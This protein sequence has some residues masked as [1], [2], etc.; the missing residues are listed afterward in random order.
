V[1]SDSSAQLKAAEVAHEQAQARCAQLE[2]ELAGLGQAREELTGK[3]AKEQ[4]VTAESG[5][6]LK[7]LEQHLGESAKEL[8]RAKAE[9][10]KQANERGRVEPELRRQLEAAGATIKQSEAAQKQAQARCAQL[11]Q[12]LAGLRQA[13]EELAGK[14]AKE[15]QSAAA[16]RARI[17][18]LK[19][20]LQSGDVERGAQITE[21]EQRVRQ[22][23]AALTRATADLAKE[24]GERQR[25]E[26]CAAAL[27]ARLQALHEE[28]SRTLQS[29][30][31]NLERISTLEEQLRQR[32]QAVAGWTAAIE[33]QQAESRV[34]EEQLRQAKDLNAQF[35]KN[36]SFF[37][38]ASKTFDRTRQDLQARLEASLSAVQESESKL[39]REGA[40]R[41]RLADALE[42]VQREL[43]SQSQ[44]RETLETQLQ[45]TLKALKE[46]EARLQKQAAERQ[47]LNDA[48][49]TAQFS[50]RDRSQR[51]ELEFSKLQSDLQLEQVERKRLETQIARIRHTSL[52]AVRAAR[53]LRNSLRRQIH[54]PVDNLYHSARSLLE[55]QMGD[56]QKKLVEAVL[57]DVLLVQARLQ[58]PEMAQSDSSDRAPEV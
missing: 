57:Q 52:N 58:H 46:S 34:A 4:Q 10:E 48:L 26:Q 47:R 29:Q 19:R 50:L 45:T 5:K 51:G 23:V 36:L 1:K 49:E 3:F 27:N 8:E 55:L 30:R 2:Q 43:Q 6:R 31:V 54:E 9:L 28:F 33:Q 7:E 32:D 16:S 25:S 38:E 24:R 42:G 13:R 44:K 41:Q 56:Q 18:E 11:E 15:Q 14:F 37:E 39:Q 17:E 12:E 20:Q 40:E 53:V 21:L 35:Q 22:G